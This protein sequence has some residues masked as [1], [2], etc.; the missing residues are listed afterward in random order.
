MDRLTVMEVFVRAADTGS[1]TAAALSLDMS[2]QMVGRYVALLEDR[3]GT[4]L[5]QR[6]TRRQSLTEAGRLFHAQAKRI[7]EEVETAHADVLAL[8]DRPRG[9]LRVTAPATLGAHCLMPSLCH[10]LRDHPEVSVDLTLSDRVVDIVEEGYDA[11]IRIGALPDSSLIARP[12]APYDFIACASPDYLARR[13]SPRVPADLAGH[14][15][16]RYAS[17]S[18]SPANTWQ[19]TRDGRTQAI[20]MTGR[21]RINDARALVAATLAGCGIMFGPMMVLKDEIGA[22]RL[23]RVLPEYDGPSRP[24]TLLYPADRRP[25]PKLRSFVDWATRLLQVRS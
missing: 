12:L 10:Y 23:V 20:G 24:I 1:F 13:G 25:S 6:T 14:E 8:G 15:C 2:P 18:H 22:G 11:A 3:L 16:L 9:T 4:R 21:L 17:T 5:L 7:L 19:F